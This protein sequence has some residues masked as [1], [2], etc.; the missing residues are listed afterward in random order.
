ME[1]EG[2]CRDDLDNVHALNRAWLE[3]DGSAEQR[4]SVRRLERLAATPFLLF[5]F[6]ERDDRYWTRLLQDAGD[7]AGLLDSQ[8]EVLAI[9]IRTEGRA[10]DRARPDRSNQRTNRKPRTRDL[11]R[12]LLDLVLRSIGI[13]VRVEDEEVDA[14]VF[15]AAD[16][17]SSGEF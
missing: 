2:L 14:V 6:R 16:I 10:T 11:V 13:G 17:G 8:H 1:Y 12:H 3:L 7:A 15:P 4:L 9:L 5:S